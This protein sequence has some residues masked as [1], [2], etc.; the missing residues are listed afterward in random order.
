MASRA[1]VLA[2]A[3]FVLAEEEETLLPTFPPL[4]CS[5]FGLVCEGETPTREFM[6]DMVPNPVPSEYTAKMVLTQGGNGGDKMETKAT[7]YRFENSSLS[8]GRVKYTTEHGTFSIPSTSYSDDA[9]PGYLFTI[10]QTESGQLNCTREVT[11]PVATSCL[12]HYLGVKFVDTHLTDVFYCHNDQPGLSSI[13][14]QNMF[15]GLPQGYI[16]SPGLANE[17]S[18][19]Y[20]SFVPGTPADHFR[21]MPDRVLNTCEPVGAIMPGNRT[22]FIGVGDE[23]RL[24]PVRMEAFLL[25]GPSV[26][27]L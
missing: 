22:G 7:L 18:V 10:G 27:Y 17:T 3:S 16:A 20:L 4:L 23:E 14:Y 25:S 15:T 9:H 12:L 26:I 5:K 19:V 1:L 8:E 11:K 2:L 13:Y 6:K 24:C 21:K